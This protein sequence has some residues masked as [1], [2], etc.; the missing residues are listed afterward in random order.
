MWMGFGQTVSKL[1]NHYDGAT[2]SPSKPVSIENCPQSWLNNYTVPEHKE[3]SSDFLH[4]PL[5][6]VSYMWFSA[7]ACIWCVV[8]GAIL[9]LFKPQVQSSELYSDYSNLRYWELY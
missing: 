7:V 4:L 2:W 9:S 6:E 5:Y 1:T 8:V 3:P